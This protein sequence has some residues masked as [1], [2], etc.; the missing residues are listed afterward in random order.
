MKRFT[1]L[2]A[3]AAIAATLLGGTAALAQPYPGSPQPQPPGWN[4]GPDGP[5]DP[6]RHDGPGGPGGP[7]PGADHGPGG[8]GQPG[9]Y[10]ESGGRPGGP[11]GPGGYGP[12][13]GPGG[14]GPGGPGPAGPGWRH[15]HRGDHFHGDRYYVRDWHH[16]GLR[17][18]PHGYRWVQNGGE[19]VLI[20]VASGVIADVILSN[21]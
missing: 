8:P 20:G 19:F 1:S 18:P 2:S 12:G 16:Y 10:A 15:W 3:A 7:G 11:G 6:N 17:P 4:H 9:A 21:R 5:G 13:P 14:P